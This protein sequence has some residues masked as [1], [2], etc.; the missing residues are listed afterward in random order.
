MENPGLGASPQKIQELRELIG[1]L[2]GGG[3]REFLPAA[4]IP[5]GIPRG[6]LVELAGAQKTEWLVAFLRANDSLLAAWIEREQ[7]VLP[8]AI[9]QRGVELSRITF[10]TVADPFAALRRIIQAQLHEVI[11]APSVFEEDRVLK[12]L[13]LLVEKANCVL[14]LVAKELRPAW[15]ISVQLQVPKG[16]SRAGHEV[17]VVKHKLAGIS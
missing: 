5:L 14:F 2:G 15:P 4:G 1:Q 7:T 6:A 10:V 8:P 17:R 11:I 12:G 16:D 13:Q 3:K 9:Q